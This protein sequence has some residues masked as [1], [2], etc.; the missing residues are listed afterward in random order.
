MFSGFEWFSMVVDISISGTFG[1]VV[2][3]FLGFTMESFL[4]LIFQYFVSK[5]NL[6]LG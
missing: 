6:F 1:G 3:Y 4:E 5:E 2:V